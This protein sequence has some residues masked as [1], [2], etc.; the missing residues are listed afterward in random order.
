[1]AGQKG[2]VYKGKRKEITNYVHIRCRVAKGS[3]K[4]EAM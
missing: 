4:K 1:V 3:S 2:M